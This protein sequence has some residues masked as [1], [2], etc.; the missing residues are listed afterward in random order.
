MDGV[1][2]ESKAS[3]MPKP[4]DLDTARLFTFVSYQDPGGE[5]FHSPQY[6]GVSIRPR[7]F[8]RPDRRA[9]W[10]RTGY[11][12]PA[13]AQ[14]SIC[15][16]QRMF[17]HPFLSVQEYQGFP[18]HKIKGSKK[19]KKITYGKVKFQNAYIYIGN[20]LNHHFWII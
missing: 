14:W 20:F 6:R 12:G 11:G 8:P 2:F 16:Q 18:A 3:P 1:M 19:M 13:C 9:G 7:V 5:T 17:F 4:Q 10:R 15:C